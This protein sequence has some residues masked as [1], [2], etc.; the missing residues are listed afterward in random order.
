MPARYLATATGRKLRSVEVT[1]CASIE[2]K[3]KIP[4]DPFKVEQHCQG[5]ADANVGKD[6]SPCVENIEGACFGHLGRKGLFHDTAVAERG[7]I[8]GRLPT[9][10]I[11]FGTPIVKAAFESFEVR[12]GVTIVVEPDLVEVPKPAIYGKVARP[13]IR[14]ARKRHALARIDLADQIGSAA[15]R[16]REG[17]L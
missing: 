3:K 11:L 7:K 14:I 5:F 13:I 8:I 2:T 1:G 10:R 9:T 12:I 15:E 6:R 17:R 16:R 4:I